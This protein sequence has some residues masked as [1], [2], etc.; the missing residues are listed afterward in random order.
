MLKNEKNPE[1]SLDMETATKILGNV[2]EQSEVEPNS[3][4][5]EVL[6]SYSSYRKER[7]SLQRTI[8]AVIM[9]LFLLLPTLFIAPSFTIEEPEDSYNSAPVYQMTVDSMLPITRVTASINGHNI[10][11]YEIDARKFS[12]EPSINGRMEVTITLFNHQSMTQY[13]NVGKVD[14]EAPVLVSNDT[15]SE[16]IYLNLSD[17]GSGINFDSIK[18]I[19]SQGNTI[20]PNYIDESKGRVGFPYPA[21]SMNVYVSDY[22]DNTLQLVIYI[23]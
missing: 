7:F 14:T 5:L 21:D 19:D 17:T 23:K 2:F 12:I 9:V 4:P 15:D 13:V 6:T 1:L 8:L 18:A 11:V 16:M 3:I 20:T 22:A 10:P